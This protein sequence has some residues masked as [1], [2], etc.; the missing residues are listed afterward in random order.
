MVAS[1]PIAR[2]SATADDCACAAAGASDLPVRTAAAPRSVCLRFMECLLCRLGAAS[3]HAFVESSSRFATRQHPKARS[4]LDYLVSTE[5][6]R[7]GRLPGH[8][9]SLQT[10]ASNHALRTHRP[11]MGSHQA[12]AAGQAARCPACE[13]PPCPERHLLGFAIRRTVARPAAGV[14]P[15]YH[16][17]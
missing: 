15:L 16:L 9:S 12:D 1:L 3:L 17:L 7:R 11:R 4:V 2:A 6:R 10:G 13:R 5:A 8:D 14:R